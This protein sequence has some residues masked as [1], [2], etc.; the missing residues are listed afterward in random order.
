MLPAQVLP[1]EENELVLDTCAAPEK[2]QELAAKLHNTDLLLSN[3]ISTS[4][5][6]GLIKPWNYP[7][8]IMPG[9]A[10]KTSLI[11]Q[12]DLHKLLIKSWLMLHV[13]EK[14]C[15]EKNHI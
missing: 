2:A 10:V 14:E 3:D 15:F 12:I 5:C 6:Q 8:L 4:R 11:F 13:V 9:Y 1:I 7:A